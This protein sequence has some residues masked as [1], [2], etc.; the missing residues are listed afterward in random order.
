MRSYPERWRGPKDTPIGRGG[1]FGVQE[2]GRESPLLLR[3]NLN[4]V[5]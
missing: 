1:G 5:R 2:L 4:E 3:R